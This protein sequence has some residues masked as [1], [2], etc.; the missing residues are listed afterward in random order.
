MWHLP[1]TRPLHDQMTE[2]WGSQGI[3]THPTLSNSE[4]RLLHIHAAASL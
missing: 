1:D 4:S 2:G 3:A